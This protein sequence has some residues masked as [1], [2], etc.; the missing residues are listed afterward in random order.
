MPC[1]APRSNLSLTGQS[2]HRNEPAYVLN[3]KGGRITLERTL[4]RPGPFSRRTASS[5]ISLTYTNEYQDYRVTEEALNTPGFLKT[6]IALGLDP[7][8]GTARGLLSSIDLDLHRSTADS[9]LNAKQGYGLD[10]HLEKAGTLLQGDY[11]FVETILEGRY[12]VPLGN[13]A[14]VAVKARGGSIGAVHGE[15]L[16][17]PFFR[18][19]W[20]GGATSLRGWGRF[21]VSPL[22][23]GVTIGG[24]TMFESSAELRVPIWGNSERG[25]VLR[26]GQRV[27]QRVGLQS[28]RSA[29][30]RRFRPPL[31]DA[32]RSAPLRLRLPAQSDPGPAHQRQAA[33]PALPLP[34]LDRPGV[35]RRK[36]TKGMLQRRITPAKRHLRRTLQVVAL[37]GTLLV[38]IIALALIVSQTPWFRE[39]LRRYAVRQAAQYVN[40]TV[41]IGSLGGNLFY[42]IELGDVSVTSMASTSSP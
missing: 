28:R 31:P 32:D 34:F 36:K 41:S 16:N 20:L 39:W 22:F 38:G 27:E 24:H 40:G 8:N 4:A 26:R 25:A 21:E 9:T 19:Y 23:D 29:E 18:R 11:E 33:E 37:V 10:A 17:V 2:W 12:Y 6:L 30:G 1:S 15:N 35:L 14:V 5:S 13:R 7:L 3:T 42:G